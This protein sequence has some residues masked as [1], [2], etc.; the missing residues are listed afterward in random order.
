MKLFLILIGL[1]AA[2]LLGYVMEPSLRLQVT[3]IAPGNLTA[4]APQPV[5]AAQPAID[6]ASLSPEQLPAKVTLKAEVKVTDPASEVTL[7]IPSGNR[8]QLVRID[9]NNAVISPG[10]GTYVGVVPISKTDL[11][12]QLA[13]TPPPSATTSLTPEPPATEAPTEP[14]PA[15]LTPEPTPAPTT[16]EDPAPVPAPEAVPAPDAAP[17]TIP[18]APAE[19]ATPTP[20]MEAPAPEPAPATT[21][22]PTPAAV[23][24]PAPEPTPAPA[25]VPAPAAASNPDTVVKLMQESVRAHQIKEFAL[26]QV[27]SWKA[28]GE[29]TIGGELFQTG[30]VTYKAETMLGVKTIQAKALIKDGKVQ[31]WVGSK[32]GLEIK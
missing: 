11:M 4:K 10:V 29:E 15:A 16:A 5:P 14:A 22:E 9:G 13:A 26:N 2:G 27:L 30:S 1:A 3:G 25:A 31:R 17:E 6:P 20:A 18:A 8:V 12:E 28:E 32:S 23:P 21:V 7:M 24:P 19:E